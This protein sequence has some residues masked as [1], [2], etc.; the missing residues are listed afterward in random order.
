MSI[1][2]DSRK[3]YLAFLISL[4]ILFFVSDSN[5]FATT[6]KLRPCISTLG[7]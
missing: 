2:F 7:F 6:C 3:S 5:S 1:A 4:V